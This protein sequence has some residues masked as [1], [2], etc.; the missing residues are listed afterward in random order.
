MIVLQRLL[1]QLR[2]LVLAT[3]ARL[4]ATAV[5]LAFVP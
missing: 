1:A 3:L 2:A 4:L 5:C